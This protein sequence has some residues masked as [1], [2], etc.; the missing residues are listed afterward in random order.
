MKK[1]TGNTSQF[2]V[3]SRMSLMRFVDT[4]EFRADEQEEIKRE[5]E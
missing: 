5:V 4:T 3:K 2:N 1:S